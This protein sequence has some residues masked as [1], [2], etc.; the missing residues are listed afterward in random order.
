M[1]PIL[2]DAFA[3]DFA[4]KPPISK[5]VVWA[6]CCGL[7]LKATEGTYYKGQSWL[8]TYWPLAKT[9]AGAR[10]G[11][12]WFRGAYLY[13]KFN[14]LG[15]LQADY[16]LQ[17]IDEVGGWDAGDLPPIVDCELG[18]DHDTNQK[19][20]KAQIEDCVST[21]ADRLKGALGRPVIL[22][23]IGA[24]REKGI[25]SRMGCDL[26]WIPNYTAKL[27]AKEYVDY[28]WDTASLFGWQYSGTE[29]GGKLAGYPY[30]IPG[31][32]E[33]ADLTAVQVKDLRALCD[34]RT[35]AEVIPIDGLYTDGEPTPIEIPVARVIKMPK[36]MPDPDPDPDDNGGTAA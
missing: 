22:Y 3:G 14:L 30:K 32:T 12:T 11:R 31:T 23:G 13:L 21:C 15:Y 33:Y 18:S 16:F 29:S 6:Q 25:T 36:T 34:Q 9:M 24:M 8:R 17:A 28:G 19:A 10:Y 1:D 20:S 26:L 27:F 5:M 2:V 35:G 4:G 7:V